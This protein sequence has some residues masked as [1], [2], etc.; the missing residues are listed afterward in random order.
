[1]YF[2]DLFLKGK[3]GKGKKHIFTLKCYMN[4]LNKPVY[5]MKLKT[6][7]CVKIGEYKCD[8]QKF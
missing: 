1:M 6:V 2:L 4:N 5:F 8:N 7:V 3:K